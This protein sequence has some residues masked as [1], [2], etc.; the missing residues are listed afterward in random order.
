VELQVPTCVHSD[1]AESTAYAPC[2]LCGHP[3]LT[4]QTLQ[5]VTLHLDVG[6]RCYTVLWLNDTPAPTL[7]HSRAYPVHRC[8]N[9]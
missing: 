7:H 3:V 6:T 1:V 4:G 8:G 5:G 9:S 2:V